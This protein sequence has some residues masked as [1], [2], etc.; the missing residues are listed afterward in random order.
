MALLGNFQR[1]QKPL[2]LERLPSGCF[3]LH[4]GGELVASTLPS[5]FP[6]ATLLEIGRVVL[7]IF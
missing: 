1:T 4:R 7:K 3:S 2:R 5:S 6:K